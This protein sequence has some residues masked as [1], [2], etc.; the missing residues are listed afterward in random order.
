MTVQAVQAVPRIERDAAEW[1][2][3]SVHS[4]KIIEQPFF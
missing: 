1:E 3:K 2:K 4:L